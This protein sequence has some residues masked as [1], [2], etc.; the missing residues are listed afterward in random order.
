MDYT[1]TEYTNVVLPEDFFGSKV[2]N[3]VMPIFTLSF[4]VYKMPSRYIVIVDQYGRYSIKE[5]EI[6]GE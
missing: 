6:N 1:E 4:P 3:S 2:E 5:E